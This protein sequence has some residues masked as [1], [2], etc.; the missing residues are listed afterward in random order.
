M[1]NNAPVCI[2]DELTFEIP[3]SWEWVRLKEIVPIC[4]GKKD[5]NFGDAKG[6]YDFFSCSMTP[7]KSKTFSYSGEYLIMPGNG[8]NVGLSIHYK[9]EFEAY[10]R[11]YLLEKAFQD[12]NF[13]YL[14]IVMLALWKDYNR[15]KQYGSAIPYIKLGNLENFCVPIPPLTEQSRI[16]SEIE[17]YEPLI[18]EY[19]KLE[20]QKSKLDGE[21]YDKL[22][23]SILQYAIQGKLVPQDENDE[24]ASEL[25]KRIRAEKKAQFGKKYVDSYIYKGDDNCY[26]E[27]IK[28]KAKDETIEVPFDLPNNWAWSKLADVIK[29]LTDGTHSTPKYTQN[30]IHFISVK[31]LSTGE[32]KLNNTKFIS[33]QEHIELSKR[34]K[35]QMGDILLTKVGTTGIP[36]LINIEVE[37]SLF[38]SVALIKFNHNYMLP[39][40]FIYL[41][42]SPLVQTQAT[43]NTRGVGNKNWVLSDIEKTM[44][45]IPP[46]AEQQR[47]V[48]KINEIFARL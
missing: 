2:E 7:I 44:L 35:P 39:D 18:A 37:F 17:K 29:L 16:V 23:K 5:V 22:K 4:T 9:G 3:D 21:L 10:Q 47:I 15:D 14:Q 31:D 1:G 12:I 25:L 43:E 28:G 42:K 45:A 38:V 30:G 8:A 24:P 6:K 19:D 41:L 46:F 40:F 36:V 33:E 20:Q 11:T 13:E 34:C 26:N 27:H 32:L 48:N